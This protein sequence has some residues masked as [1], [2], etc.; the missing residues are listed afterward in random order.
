MDGASTTL[1]LQGHLDRLRAGDLAARG[2][3]VRCAAERLTRLARKLLRGYP[4]VR[5]WEQTDDVLQNALLRLDRS[6]ERLTPPTPRDYF[7]LAACYIRRELLDLARRYAGR[8]AAGML[9]AGLPEGDNALDA[10]QDEADEPRR[11]AAW[12][13]FHLRAGD[14]PEEEREVFDLLWYQGRCQA[15]AALLLGVSERTI[16]RRWQAARLLLHQA[17]CGE[18]PV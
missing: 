12:T 1:I 6:L 13:E 17:L 18:L 9:P 11:L 16:K 5:P 14:L 8:C 10:L 3:L 2:E 7:R 15:E 4:N